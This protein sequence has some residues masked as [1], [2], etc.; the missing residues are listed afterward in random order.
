MIFFRNI[1]EK[2]KNRLKF[3]QN[4]KKFTRIGICKCL[5]GNGISAHNEKQFKQHLKF[6]KYKDK[7]LI[8]LKQNN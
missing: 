6:Q 5:E 1:S 2:Y 4:N 8:S 7:G 3:T